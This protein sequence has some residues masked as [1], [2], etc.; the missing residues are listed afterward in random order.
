MQ[1]FAGSCLPELIKRHALLR[2]FSDR[3]VEP[4]KLRQVLEAAH[5]TT[6]Y[7]NEQP[8]N[9][10]IAAKT[11]KD[12]YDTLL[13]CVGDP[14]AGW[15]RRAPVLI[16]SVARLNFAADG[17]PNVHAFHDLG[18]ATSNMVLQAVAI[19]LAVHQMAGFDAAGVRQLFQ[20]P[21]GHSPVAVTAVG[22]AD[23]PQCSSGATDGTTDAL[24]RP[25]E[26]FVFT[27]QWGQTSPLLTEPTTNH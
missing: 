2:S 24:L 20:I 17:T 14:S 8:W 4:E 3:P 21:S 7:R 22:Y 16:L 15:A 12:E 19:G 1:T 10:I 26:S 11:Y 25:L 27:S 18:K 13:S 5:R 6:S 9:F 23:T